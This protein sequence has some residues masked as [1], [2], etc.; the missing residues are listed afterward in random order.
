MI[1]YRTLFV[2]AAALMLLDAVG[3]SVGALGPLRRA[4]KSDD[5]YWTRRLTLNLLLANQ[6]LYF[7]G[8]AAVIG[9]IYIDTQP[10]AANAVEILCFLTCVYTVVTVPVLTPKDWPH[11]LP[12]AIAGVLILIAWMV[13]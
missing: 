12:R 8:L 10:K 2:I 1:G 9:A 7:A 11:V 5:P 4:L 6:G 3:Y 13:R